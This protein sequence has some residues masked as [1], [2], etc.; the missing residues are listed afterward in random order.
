MNSD[1]I[2]AT[3]TYMMCDE[4]LLNISELLSNH[5]KEMKTM[6]LPIFLNF[7]QL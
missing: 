3:T 1:D 7:G 6:R 5:V 4:H 2:S